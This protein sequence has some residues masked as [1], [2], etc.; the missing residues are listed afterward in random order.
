L[1]SR[2]RAQMAASSRFGE[3]STERSP[4]ERI[5]SAPVGGAAFLVIH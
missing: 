1:L 3:P 4:F 5:E 2:V